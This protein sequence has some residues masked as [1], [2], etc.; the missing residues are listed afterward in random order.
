MRKKNLLTLFAALSVSAVFSQS[1]PNGGFENW[2]TTSCQNPQY[3]MSSNLQ[4]NGGGGGL[5]PVN[6]V[7][8]SDSYHGSFAV[9]L[10]TVLSGADTSAAY[11]TN[12]IIGNSGISG[13]IPINQKPNGM[14]LYY[15]CNVPVGDTA[16]VILF[17]KV[18]GTVFSQTIQKIYGTQSTYTLLAI[19]LSLA[20]TPDSLVFAAVSSN[21]L[22]G[23]FKGIPGSM[24]QIDSVSF[25]GI[26]SQ[27]ANMNGDFETW[28]TFSVFT[29]Q[30]WDI[31]SSRINNQTTDK[32]A[33]T[34][35]LE[36]KTSNTNNTNDSTYASSATTGHSVNNGT[37]GGHPYSNSTDTLIFNY[38][39]APADPNDSAFIMLEF[40]KAGVF[41]NNVMRLVSASASYKQVKVGF[42][43]SPTPDSVIVYIGSSKKF[44]PLPISYLGADLKIDNMYFKS[45]ASPVTSF[46]LPSSGCVGQA[47]LLTDMSGN[48]PTTW[49][50]TATNGTLSNASDQNPTVTYTANGTYT[51]T[52]NTGNASGSGTPVSQTITINVTP[53][54]T[55]SGTTAICS[56]NNTILTGNGAPSFTWSANAGSATTATISVSPNTTDTYT[57]TGDNGTC[58]STQTVTINVTATPTL[59]VTVTSPTVCSGTRDTLRVSGATSY[60]WNP[61]GSHATIISGII[62][63]SG[64]FTVTGANGTCTSVAT[65]VISVIPSP[66][67]TIGGTT[68]IC[69]G[70]ST[71]LTGSGATTYTWSA[72][73]GG[74]TTSTV[75]VN[76]N[77]STVYTL[78]GTSGTCIS[79]KTSSVNVIT[80][81]TV[82]ITGATT[83]CSGN[84]TI[85]TGSGAIT[86]TWSANAGSATTST[87][88]VNPGTTDTYTLTG[89]NG[90]GCTNVITYTLSVTPT[91]TV[92]ISGTTAICSGNSTILTGSGATT[93]TWS[94]NAGIAT[95]T[96]FSENMGTPGATTPIS[97]YIGFQNYGTLVFSG[98]GDVRATTASSG[99]AGASGSGNVFLTTGGSQSFQI[100]SINTSTCSAPALS[101]G[102]YKS[103][104]TSTG[105][106]LLIE[107]ST[108]GITYNPVSMPALPTGS[109]TAAWYLRTISSGIP[110]TPNLRL[111]FTNTATATQFRIDDVVL[112]GTGSAT[113]SVSPATTD[114]YTLTG[115]NGTCSSTKTITVNVTA[116]PTVVISGATTVCLGNSATL[117]ASGATS[118]SWSAN[119][120]SATTS[121]VSV[122]P[123]ANAT[124][125]ITG[126]N[127]G[128]CTSVKT[129]TLSV[130]A[131]PTVTISG[132]TAICSGKSTTL[133]GNGASTYTW[134]AGPTSASY[135][136]SPSAT[137]DYTVTGTAVNNC[138]N[139]ATVTV[140]VAASPTI[141][142]NTG[143]IC[144][145]QQSA[146]LTA[147]GAA[148]YT[149]A[150]N[151]GLS[152][153]SGA[154]VTATPT[155][156]THYTI[157]GTVG[158]CTSTSTSTVTVNPLPVVAV[159]SG[160]ICLGQQTAT[161]TATGAS[162]YSWS[163][164]TDL[165]A[166]TGTT[167]IA[168]PTV[169]TNYTIT[170][171]DINTC[172]T[173]ATSTVIVNPLPVVTV[174]SG[175]ICL[176]QQTATLTAGGASTYNWSPAIGLSSSSGTSVLSNPTVTIV[177]TVT[178][179]DINTCSTTATSTVTV[180]SLPVPA[181]TSNGPVCI[182]QTLDLFANGGVSYSWVGPNTYSSNLQNP[183]QPNVAIT[184]SGIYTVTVTDA[185]GCIGSDTV[186]AIVNGCSS[187]NKY[188]DNLVSIFPNPSSGMF[189]VSLPDANAVASVFDLTG[190]KVATFNLS[191]TK[192]Q[193]D[194]SAFTDGIYFIEIT[195]AQGVFRKKITKTN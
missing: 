37:I 68:T 111:R 96:L 90:G 75:S 53:T 194:L 71:T 43:L 178:G 8:T 69:S 91:P 18:S 148:T 49:T 44:N 175:T 125:T 17:F 15:K 162:T 146:T 183:S 106:E 76:P 119:A 163:P 192:S 98:T 185:N 144:L 70:N 95:T 52:L 73:A 5:G 154:S 113:V 100:S 16:L 156:T 104:I 58:T 121:T 39:Y 25:T 86:Y 179:A 92:N 191:N 48:I 88:S 40:K 6:V 33:G 160:T 167:V 168:N 142:V 187:L 103:T 107:V 67:I 153:T 102:V 141:A 123:V 132:T 137:T 35:A 126:D 128:G 80:T 9:K 21:K 190:K 122:S 138:V 136:V 41:T 66:T 27:P 14:R 97:S 26:S 157:T 22:A 19:P 82:S 134:T 31:S 166:P 89:D 87:V 135:T 29:L 60:T 170:S 115:S 1:I 74:A 171:T 131:T 81:P 147:N 169:T 161:L 110:V 116:T 38:K 72:N 145:G 117:T 158:T 7:Q 65:Q 127:G 83:I 101:F 23:N 45:Q 42:T 62:N 94:A 173:T 114:T 11:F 143:S 184:A 109:G 77:T 61:T 181:P 20:L 172:T 139:T 54:V 2:T 120:G 176:G 3:Y 63:T 36:L 193:I 47:V 186:T 84:S 129:Y 93:Y 124:Y 195:T 149:W 182:N 78:T 50:W 174:T 28:Q 32:F 155:T 189:I 188:A 130:K 151:T 133:T 165:S 108:D 64:T 118:Y 12:G 56:G 180:N 79:T 159:N 24:L 30:N 140:T 152:S 4:Q 177:Y 112:T 164:N 10:S 150:P 34:Y 57:V 105:S 59:I 85:L 55:I 99:Y 51:V 46:T 13:G